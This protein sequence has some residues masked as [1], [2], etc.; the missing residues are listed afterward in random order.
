MIDH[1]RRAILVA[2]TALAGFALVPGAACAQEKFKA[3]TTFTV[4]A[5]MAKNVAG[6]AAI[7]ESITKPGAEI[8]NYQPTPRDILKAHDAKLILWNGLNLELWFEK[9]FQNF[10]EVPGVVV[11]QGIEPMGIAEGPYSG[12]PNPHAWMSPSAALIYVDNIRDA[13]VKYD[14]GN[15]E[16]YKANAEAYKQKIEAA[17]APIRAEIGKIPE[18][19]RWLVSSEGAFSYLTRD[20]GMK[21]LYLWPINADQ[22]GTP[23][24][25]RK[26]I[27]AVRANN[28][29]VVFSESTISP[30]PA[31]QVARETGAKYG[32]VLYVDSLSEA[33][34]PVPTYIDLLRV[35]SE[36]IAKGLSQ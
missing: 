3:V 26:V 5:D 15:A 25:V 6:D 29:P 23:Q 20:F 14:P 2:A 30:D 21:E 10:D 1:T 16:T 35:T 7:V 19:K 36:T 4:I 27:D 34:G 9:F 18:D 33:D 13:F 8:H 17:I 11:S 31:Q 28:I 32:G 22:Q 24:Q 12:K